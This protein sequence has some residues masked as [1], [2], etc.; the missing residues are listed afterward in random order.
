MIRCVLA[1]SV[2]LHV[3]MFAVLPDAPPRLVR[4]PE[5]PS[6]VEVSSEPPKPKEAPPPEPPPTPATTA[7]RPTTMNRASVAPAQAIATAA[8]TGP[9]SDV[10]P[11]VAVDG[12]GPADFTASVISNAAPGPAPKVVVT[13]S[14]PI[15]PAEPKMVPASSLS[16]R[17]GAPGLD[18]ELEKNYPIEARRSG[19]SGT[20]KL[21]VQ[22]LSDGRV[23][24]VDRVSESYA[25]F[26]DACAKTVRAAR[27]EPPLDKDGRAV[28]TEIV[29]VCKFEIRS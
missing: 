26:G 28:A 3:A 7:V 27:W 8:P 18:A 15:V 2:G 1:A 24:R 6:L 5:T 17:P 16:R 14:A 12:D 22:I 29:Y 23:G 11:G 4:A 20:A 25:G 19:V 13:T 10:L 9:V 21:R